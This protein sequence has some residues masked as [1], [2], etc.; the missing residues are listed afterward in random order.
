MVQR[1]C[2]VEGCD[3][4]ARAKGYCG[5]H[6]RRNR[7]DGDP[8]AAHIRV[9]NGTLLKTVVANVQHQSEACLIWPHSRS[10]TGYP[11]TLLVD[12]KRI[13]A[14]RYMCILAHGPPPTP[15]H[16]ARHL[17]GKGHEGC[18]NPKHLAW[19]TPKQNSADML[20]HGT[21]LLGEAAPWTKFT[22]EQIVAVY[23]D[24]RGANMLSE[25]TGMTLGTIN[26][27]RAGGMRFSLT[28]GLN[29]PWRKPKGE[30]TFNAKLTEESVHF[31]RTSGLSLNQL[32]RK[33]G[34]AKKTV[35]QVRQ[36]KTWKH[37]H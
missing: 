27:I 14:H 11:C 9:A 29:Q 30:D 19:G 7:V 10:N 6:Y 8:G 32:A 31:I 21:R 36:R 15:A 37:V 13:S 3:R 34:V 35:L 4:F 23:L 1:K 12:N 28:S 24:P 25:Q 22:D 18:F 20:T 5:A 17:C 33:F 16:Y 2:S 26:N